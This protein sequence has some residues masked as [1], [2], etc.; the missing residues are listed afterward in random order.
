MTDVNR[1]KHMIYIKY[2]AHSD[3]IGYCWDKRLNRMEINALGRELSKH[4][5]QDKALELELIEY[6]FG[7]G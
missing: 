5:V 7:K 2:E 1:G 3:F 4:G 6:I